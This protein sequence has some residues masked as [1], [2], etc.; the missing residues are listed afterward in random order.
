MSFEESVS[1]EHSVGAVGVY[2]GLCGD[3]SDSCE[4]EG[5]AL[6]EIEA[7]DAGCGA[8]DDFAGSGVGDEDGP[9]CGCG[10]GEGEGGGEGCEFAGARKFVGKCGH[11][12]SKLVRFGVDTK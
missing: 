3:G 8:E 1:D 7:G 4:D 5:G 6:G 10:R 11:V 9:G 2:G 12:D